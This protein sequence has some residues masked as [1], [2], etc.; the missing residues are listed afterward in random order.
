MSGY[1]SIVL[2]KARRVLE[3]YPL[4]D[5]CLGRLYARL[6][7]GWSNRDRGRS[8][9][10]AIVMESHWRIREGDEAEREWLAK[11]AGSIGSVALPLAREVLGVE[12]GEERCYICGGLLDRVIEESLDDAAA[13]ARAYDVR[14]LVVGAIVDRGV[15]E[16][17]EEVKSWAGLPYG[18]SIKSEIRREVGKRLQA[19]GFT[20]DFDEPEATVHVHYPSGRVTIQVNSLLVKGRYWK[21]GRNISQ[22]YW[23]SPTGPRYFS[24]EEALW[25]LLRLTGGERLVIHASGREDV[26]ARMLGTGRPVIVEVKAPR[27]RRVTPG[28][29]EEAVAE[30]SRGVVVFRMEGL[31]RRREVQL[32]KEEAQ[33]RAKTYKALVA[34]SQPPPEGWPERL[35]EELEGRVVSQWTPRRVLHRRPNILRRKRVYR[36]DCVEL[37]PGLG[38]CLITGEG[39][40]YIKELVSGDEGRTEPSFASILGVDAACVE[41]DVVSV[42][43][44]SEPFN[45][46]RVNGASKRGD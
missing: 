8:L 46:S 40:L 30:T 15:L 6:G 43:Q 35:R 45:T 33:E 29:V 32:Y 7:Y 9:K 27:R 19:M 39:G 4:C 44:A 21:L 17:E 36:V 3:R 41:L 1:E 34:F 13:L 5:R 24:V 22:A 25:G 42:H 12:A 31:A 2:A 10:M 23:P 38:E 37:A 11:H 26:D 28:E 18:E 20:V 16:R 14:R